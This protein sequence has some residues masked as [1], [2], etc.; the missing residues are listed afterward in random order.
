[1]PKRRKQTNDLDDW[2]GRAVAPV[3]VIDMERRVR[4]FNAGCERLTG[5]RADEV[6]GE[7]CHYGSLSEIAGVAALA[8]SLCP[9]PE[10]FQGSSQS[11]PAH[12]VHQQGHALPRRLHFFP[13]RDEK[14]R[15]SGVLGVV[16]EL[17][18]PDP[19]AG[20]SPAQMLHAELAALRM[21]L[22]SRF[23]SST[24][25]ARSPA[26]RRVLTQVEI[27][28]SHMAPVLFSGASGSGKEH[29]AR[30]IHFGGPARG[31]WFV[32]LDCRRLGADELERVLTR[33]IESA[34][35]A[36]GSLAGASPQPGSV[37]LADV[38]FL[39][40]DLQER[41]VV[42]YSNADKPPPVRLLTATCLALS[43]FVADPKLRTDFQAFIS[44]MPIEVPSLALRPG[45]L[46]LLAQHFLEEH[47]RDEQKQVG[48]FADDVWPLL[49]RYEWPGN[50]DELAAVVFE[51]RKHAV[52]ALIRPHDLPYRFR[53]A[54]AAQELPAPPEPPPMLLD[55]LLTKV[56]TRLITLALARSRN[57]KSKAA[58][59]LGI[60]RA[61][62][63]RRIEQL[64]IGQP[65]G[66][67][68]SDEAAEPPESD[69]MPD[70]AALP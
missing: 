66:D 52:E 1:M 38:E 70:D 43:A 29:L 64:Q 8:A 41:L 35:P 2:L 14:D 17:P 9:P 40:R 12:L 15:L 6:L 24:L 61:R 59:L 31:S 10:V 69:D 26:M 23:G 36:T 49:A 67:T 45:D 32:P 53:T 60:N 42:L 39:P 19:G 13:L 33:L 11:A 16:T 37:F 30:V 5:W 46:P 28:R 44:P 50:L 22:R 18:L 20:A 27:A 56:E 68:I 63:L 58:E 3:F 7:A 48:G 65:A 34:R 21:T 57:N 51:A 47:N 62:L 54:L 55:P 25:V 4:A